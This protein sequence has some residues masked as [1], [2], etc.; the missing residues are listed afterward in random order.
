M[1]SLDR[2][3][4]LGIGKLKRDKFFKRAMSSGPMNCW[5][6]NALRSLSARRSGPNVIKVIDA[7]GKSR[8]T[9]TSDIPPST[10][11]TCSIRE[12]TDGNGFCRISKSL[13]SGS[14]GNVQLE[15]NA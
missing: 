5:L 8:R 12:V 4:L 14:D 1:E 6:S 11:I 9:V 10:A 13:V 7:L 15:I 3:A 2:I